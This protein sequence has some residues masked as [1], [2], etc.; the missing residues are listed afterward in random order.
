MFWQRRVA[1][2]MLDDDDTTLV[3]AVPGAERQDRV[4]PHT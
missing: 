2:L 4:S 1:V 3:Q